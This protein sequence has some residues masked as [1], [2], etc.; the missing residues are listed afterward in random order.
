MPNGVVVVAFVY[1]ELGFSGR[2][3]RARIVL[4]L[5]YLCIR[6]DNL[7]SISFCMYMNFDFIANSLSLSISLEAVT[8]EKRLRSLSLQ[9]GSAKCLMFV[10]WFVCLFG[11]CEESGNRSFDSRG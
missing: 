9:F 10:S 5:I 3:R 6:I 11:G 2:D 7:I 1:L 8:T 4:F